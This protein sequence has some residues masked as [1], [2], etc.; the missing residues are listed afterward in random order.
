M[1]RRV[2]ITGGFGYLGGR[3]ANFL[4][5]TGYEVRILANRAIATHPTWARDFDVCI[6]DITD[7]KTLDRA[8]EGCDM[9]VHLAAMNTV[10]CGRD[11]VK[12][13]RVNIEGTQNL[14]RSAGRSGIKCLIYVSTVHV[15]GSTVM[16]VL[17]EMSPTNNL[18]PYAKT[19]KAA[20]DVVR[21]TPGMDGIVLRV[22][23]A[24]GPPMNASVNCWMLVA[25]DLCRQ[26]A[27]LNRLVLRGDGTDLRDFIAISEVLGGITHFLDSYHKGNIEDLFNLVSGEVLSTYS[28][29]K[30][31]AER[32][33]LISGRYP[34]IECGDLS[35]SESKALYF[36][37]ERLECAGFTPSRDITNEIDTL[38]TF[39]FQN[40]KNA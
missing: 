31:V 35:Q 8:L 10:D 19:H 7:V 33:L 15:Y 13:E 28:L 5:S 4:P 30:K 11:P 17:D 21:G 22:S 23:N 25:N 39:C 16:G 18:H 40:F 29:A 1:S 20:E 3:L 36:S 37:N 32:A 24:V 9:V 14:V 2:A 26:V 12:A 27:E 34:K 6:A 38:L